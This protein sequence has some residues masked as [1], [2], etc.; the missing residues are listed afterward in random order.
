MAL[1]QQSS[2]KCLIFA[3]FRADLD[4]LQKLLG[5]E[6]VSFHGGIKDDDRD[7]AKRRFMRDPKVKFFLGQPRSAGVGHTLTAAENVIFYSNDHSLR[8]R[9]E[10]EKRA[11]RTGLKTKLFVWDLVASDTQ[12]EKIVKSLREKKK[13]ADVILKDPES[14][15]LNYEK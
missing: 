8:L 9:E 13:L 12:D 7:E 4:L 14:F 11:H 10:C 3:R 2:G 5:K 6:A 1:L 15:F